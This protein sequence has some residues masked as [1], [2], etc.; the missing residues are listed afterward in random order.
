[1]VEV[2]DALDRPLGRMPLPHVHRQGLRHRSVLVLVYNPLGQV[3]L[4]KRSPHKSLYPGRWD[5]SATGHVRAGESREEA[6][7]RELEEEL[8]IRAE[9]LDL[10]HKVDAGPETGWE[11]VTLFTA[12][13]LDQEPW[14]NPQ[15]VADGYFYEPGELNCLVE[16]FRD[17]T[18]PG[19][20]HFWEKGLIF[21]D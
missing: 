7:L 9:K 18:T 11:F 12:G 21:P 13:K 8:G 6:G 19:L 17:L 16:R 10:V 3:Y 4:Q 5:I 14:P 1:M 20:V 2:V 15:E